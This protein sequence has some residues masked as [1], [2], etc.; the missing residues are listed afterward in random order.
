MAFQQKGEVSTSNTNSFRQLRRNHCMTSV[1][2][3]LPP[4]SLNGAVDE[5]GTRADSSAT[6]L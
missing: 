3:T 5:Q 1:V 4:H 6:T 2:H